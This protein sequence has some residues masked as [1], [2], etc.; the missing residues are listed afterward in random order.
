M[1]ALAALG[2]RDNEIG[3]PDTQTGRMRVLWLYVLQEALV[4]PDRSATLDWL[5]SIDDRM[6]CDLAGLD[7]AWVAERFV[8]GGVVVGW[9]R[10]GKSVS[11]REPKRK[12]T[13][14]TVVVNEVA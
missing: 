1:T 11:T 5:L 9:R 12:R 2:G 10:R 14:D 8:D 7:P 4:D 6:V 3:L 13:R